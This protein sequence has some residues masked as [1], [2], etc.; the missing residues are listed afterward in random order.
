MHVFIS[1]AHDNVRWLDAPELGLLKFWSRALPDATFWYDRDRAEGLRGG[2]RWQARIWE[3]VD[4]ASVA[5]LLVS[6]DFLISSFII[7]HEVPRI[8]ARAHRGELEIVPVLIEPADWEEE[9]PLCAEF[10][11]TPGPEPLS[12]SIAKSDHDWKEARMTVLRALRAAVARAKDRSSGAVVAAASPEGMGPAPT[13]P[14]IS[15]VASFPATLRVVPL[16]PV[17]GPPTASPAESAKESDVL[18]SPRPA[19]AEPGVVSAAQAPDAPMTLR[20]LWTCSQS[21]H[22]WSA[23]AH[24]AGG[25]FT[26]ERGDLLRLLLYSRNPLFVAL[27]VESLGAEEEVVSESEIVPHPDRG[28]TLDGAATSLEPSRWHE[29]A[30]RESD[31]ARVTAWHVTLVA[32][33]QPLAHDVDPQPSPSAWE[34]LRRV[35]RPPESSRTGKP[36]GLATAARFELLA[37]LP[38]LEVHGRRP[39]MLEWKVRFA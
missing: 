11:L 27:R 14:P 9:L 25:A 17:A 31:T 8:L 19:V 26:A 32:D 5:V 24:E 10:Q 3:E 23:I 35:A 33:S 20:L 4:K 38:P 29:L 22:P 12:A 37:P 21:A 30:M 34:A 2:D 6:Q 15:E 36:L 18:A 7:K 16:A 28:G 1:Y 39:L 13:P